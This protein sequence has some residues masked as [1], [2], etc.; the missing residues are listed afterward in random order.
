MISYIKILKRAFL[1]PH[2]PK[3]YI[4]K[5]KEEKKVV[6]NITNVNSLK[7]TV[8]SHELYRNLNDPDL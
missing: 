3:V 6:K 4:K 7:P 2:N 1:D 5:P 8:S